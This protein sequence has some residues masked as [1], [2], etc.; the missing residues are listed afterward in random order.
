MSLFKKGNII[1]IVE[2][3]ENE[4]KEHFIERGNFIINQYP[5]NDDEYELLLKYSGHIS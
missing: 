4:P 2:E 3:E 5:K 1:C